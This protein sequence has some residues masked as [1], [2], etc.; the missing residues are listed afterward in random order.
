MLH[1]SAL[2]SKTASTFSWGAAIPVGF[3]VADLTRMMNETK[4]DLYGRIFLR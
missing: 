4:N 3:G 1:L 2:N